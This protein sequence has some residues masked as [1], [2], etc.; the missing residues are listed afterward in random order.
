[1]IDGASLIP[2]NEKE[3]ILERLGNLPPEIWLLA[4]CHTDDQRTHWSDCKLYFMWLKRLLKD[5]FAGGEE[6]Q[7]L[8]L[9][10]LKEKQFWAKERDSYINLYGIIHYSWGAI[11]RALEKTQ[12]DTIHSPGEMLI[13]VLDQKATMMFYGCTEYAPPEFGRFSPRKVYT[14]YRKTF[15][16][17]SPQEAIANLSKEKLRPDAY[18][19]FCLTIAEQEARRDSYLREKLT[20]YYRKWS[21]LD[22]ELYAQNH[23]RKGEPGYQWV[24]GR[25]EALSKSTK[26]K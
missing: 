19:R 21:E 17:K 12:V 25:K 24:N 15:K 23:P 3:A 1:M 18:R 2:L 22:A 13:K 16:Y 4:D 20:Y 7:A 11:R 10:P 5:Y 14:E 6:A 26:K 9:L 8:D